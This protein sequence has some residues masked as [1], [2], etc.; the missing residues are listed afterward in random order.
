MRLPKYLLA[1]LLALT[2]TVGFL[3][4]IYRLD[5][6]PIGALVDEMH[7]GYIAYSLLQ[8]G[9]DEHGVSWPLV[10]KAFGDYKLPGYAY[11]LLP[12]I[13]FFD[14]SVTTI[15]LPSVLLGT[16]NILLI[17]FL[18]KNMKF[19]TV[20][21][22]VAAVI[23]AVSPWSFILS[24]FGFES[25]LGLT[26]WLVGLLLL[27][28][29]ADETR[30]WQKILPGFFTGLTW[31]AYIAYRPISVIV[32]LGYLGYALWHKNISAKSVALV[33]T[34]FIVTIIPLLLPGVSSVN[35]VRFNQIGILKDQGLIL[36]I[37]ESRAFCSWEMP[38]TICYL[39]WNKPV[40]IT[41]QLMQRY[42]RNF[43]PEYLAI[44]GE[45]DAEYLTVAGFGTFSY[46]LYP[47][48]L[49]G[50]LYLILDKSD[51]SSQITKQH[52]LLL[53]LGIFVTVLPS[54][55]SGEPQRVRLSAVLPFFVLIITYGL[56]H[57]RSIVISVY[58]LFRQRA[59]TK[60]LSRLL[61]LVTI[62]TLSILFVFNTIQYFFDYYYV[63]TT[64]KDYQYNTHVK[65]LMT[66]LQ[67]FEAT[68]HIYI[69]PFFSDPIMYYAFY[70]KYNPKKYQQ[71]AVLA[72]LEP[73]GFQHTKQLGSVVLTERLMEDLACTVVANNQQALYVSN[74]S[75]EDSFPTAH[76]ITSTNG[77]TREVY[78]YDLYRYGIHII[79]NCNAISATEKQRISAD[80]AK[81][82]LPIE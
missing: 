81:N 50:I 60:K 17:Y 77:A 34:G 56:L 73:S 62:G 15:R 74:T 59:I 19:P 44:S 52:R 46:V 82:N 35:T 48:F 22:L 6:S 21:A 31:Y 18:A 14:L 67:Q 72:D 20:G 30:N 4:R 58:E 2:I 68:H 12:F 13:A 41:T 54:T 28:K 51:G 65:P 75:S 8:T 57:L 27:T 42:I 11:L 69:K 76:L 5:V 10:F 16:L 43:S 9:A 7:F 71:E 63:Y 47:F 79:A 32:L 23:M 70:T 29:L 36:Q 55:L 80:F 66:Y 49:I 40:T 26:F 45:P 1:V 24:R 53:I 3:L 33:M 37:N 25:N 39:L 78:I 38:Q 61:V 64:R